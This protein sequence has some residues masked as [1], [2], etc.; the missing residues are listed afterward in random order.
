MKPSI[1]WVLLS[2]DAV[3]RAEAQLHEDVTGV[4]DEIG[5]LQLHSG[6]A[7]WFFPGT[8]VLHTRLRYVLFIPWMYRDLANDHVHKAV[9][10][11]VT[12]IE[13][14]L[15]GRLREF[16]GTIGKR[17]YPEPTSQQPTFV[18]WTALGTWGLLRRRLDRTWPTKA[19]LHR[20]IERQS[21]RSHLTDDDGHYL[22]DE[23]DHFICT[24]KPPEEWHDQNRTLTF[25][26]TQE[27]IEFVKNLLS[28]IPKSRDGG[29]P[30]LLSNLA[31][32]IKNFDIEHA[33]EPW[34]QPV[35]QFADAED[36]QILQRSRNAAAF[37]AIGRAVYAALVETIREDEDGLPTDRRHR[38]HLPKMINIF[39]AESQSLDIHALKVDLPGLPQYFQDVVA[40][41]LDWLERPSNLLD[42]REVYANAEDTRKGRRARLPKRY[43][44]KER[45]AEWQPQDQTLAEPI[46]YRWPNVT[47]LLKDLKGVA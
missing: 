8:S 2:K 41:T 3:S 1:G 32:N 5:F 16:D 37:S 21:I 46:H 12:R 17:S 30:S 43:S 18:Y 26:M 19:Q 42:L 36:R 7:N 6:Y 38:E 28:A 29:T 23:A 22:D 31:E 44:A 34:N 14:N 20:M 35:L 27:E 24:P 13:T 4:R 10:Q 47:R 11:H 15:A 40:A 45:R 25:R 33:D 9:S 39:M